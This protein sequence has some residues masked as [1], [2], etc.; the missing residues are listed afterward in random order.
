MR[1]S[2]GKFEV[3]STGG[4]TF[5]GGEDFDIVIQNH[6]IEYFKKKNKIDVRDDIIALQRLREA[7]EKA[8]K[9]LD[10]TET[11]EINLPYLTSQNGSAVHFQ[12]NLTKKVVSALTEKIIQKSM[13]PVAAILADAGYKKEQIDDVLLVGGMTRMPQVQQAVEAFFGKKP[14]KNVNPDEAVAVGA[15]IQVQLSSFLQSPPFSTH[16]FLE[17]FLTNS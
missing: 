1:L 3:K 6:M 13:K 5:L 7:A 9:E 8:K 14:A 16:S 17:I 4:D 12:M 2:G 15:A 10:A 11:T